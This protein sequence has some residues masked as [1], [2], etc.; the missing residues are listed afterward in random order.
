MGYAMKRRSD[1]DMETDDSVNSE[2]SDS[3]L[4]KGNGEV[5]R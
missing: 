3:E 5:I 4:E 1:V 2:R